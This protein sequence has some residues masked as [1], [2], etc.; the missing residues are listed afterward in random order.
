MCLFLFLF[1]QKK[2][3]FFL[4]SYGSFY[5]PLIA[6]KQE[7]TRREEIKKNK[8]RY[9]NNNKSNL[10]RLLFDL[11]FSAKKEMTF[12]KRQISISGKDRGVPKESQ[13]T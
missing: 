13:Q 3:H 7:I 5:V 12:A 11:L 10:Q 4:L 1:S 6:N 2:M 8:N 9:Y